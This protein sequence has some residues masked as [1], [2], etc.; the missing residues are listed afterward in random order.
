MTCILVD[1]TMSIYL[2]AG[3]TNVCSAAGCSI[4]HEQIQASVFPAAK[5]LQEDPVLC[6]TP[7]VSPGYPAILMVFCRHPPLS[8]NSFQVVLAKPARSN[9][10]NN[11]MLCKQVCQCLPEARL[12]DI[13]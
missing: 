12:G 1:D 7:C 13:S 2:T 4:F 5:S 3:A 9:P 10:N 8:A 11:A 6:Q